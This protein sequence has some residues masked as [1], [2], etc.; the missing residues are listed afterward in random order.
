[1][2]MKTTEA[3]ARH[4]YSP[5]I[6]KLQPMTMKMTMTG[7]REMRRVSTAVWSMLCNHIPT[8]R[9]HF[10]DDDIASLVF[11]NCVSIQPA[12]FRALWLF[13]L[14]TSVPTLGLGSE[15]LMTTEDCGNSAR[16]FKH[17]PQST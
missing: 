13:L 7:T 15:T 9:L 11:A 10:L 4:G 14:Q 1:M 12:R 17:V 3:R 16:Y 5:A 6:G 2:M 8:C